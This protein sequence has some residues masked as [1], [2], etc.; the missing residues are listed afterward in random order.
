MIHT[1]IGRTADIA[2]E[3]FLPRMGVFSVT[4][5]HSKATVK[6]FVSPQNPRLVLC[7]PLYFAFP[8]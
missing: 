4:L 6:S 8:G 2:A 3:G 1:E 7:E 5:S